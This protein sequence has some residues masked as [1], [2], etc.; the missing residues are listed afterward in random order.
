MTAGAHALT[1]CLALAAGMAQAQTPAAQEKPA[2]KQKPGAIDGPKIDFIAVDADANGKLSKEE[3]R[4][5]ADLASAFDRLDAD[6]DG[7]MSKI[8]FLQWSRAG[9]V[10]GVPRDPA[11]APSGSAGAQHVPTPD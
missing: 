2:Q 8:E 7:S 11:T 6:R 1:L 9:K 3:T 5:I 4:V 10:P